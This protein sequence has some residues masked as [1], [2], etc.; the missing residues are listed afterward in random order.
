[1]SLNKDLIESFELLALNAKINPSWEDF[2]LKICRVYSQSFYTP[3]HEVL[4]LPCSFVLSQYFSSQLDDLSLEDAYKEFIEKDPEI[5]EQNEALLEEHI[6]LWN[7]EAEAKK[8]K[9][10]QV[11]TKN[12]HLEDEN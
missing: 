2:Y 12:F 3:L 9:K 5:K 8:N 11:F 1:M 7:E 10:E 4:K 6:K